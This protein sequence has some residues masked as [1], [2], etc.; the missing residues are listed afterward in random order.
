M[1]QQK[2]TKELFMAD[3]RYYKGRR[4]YYHKNKSKTNEN[5]NEAP[6]QLVQTVPEL[7]K[8]VSENLSEETL[9]KAIGIAWN[10][11]C[12]YEENESKC[13]GD[14]EK[15][16]AACED[17]DSWCEMYYRLIEKL[18]AFLK[19]DTDTTFALPELTILMDK[20]GLEDVEGLWKAK[21]KK[22]QEEKSKS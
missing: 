14:S 21:K 4:P 10:K 9:V 17:T 12:W 20:Y 18:K 11:Y 15:Y 3:K 19:I 8:A 1:Y 7:E 6:H 22:P 5:P 13:E 2:Q 16:T